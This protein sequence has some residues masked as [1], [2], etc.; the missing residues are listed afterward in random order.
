MRSS[1]NLECAGRLRVGALSLDLAFKSASRAVAVSGP[2]GAGKTTFLRVLA[3][4]AR[5]EDG[6]VSAGTAAWQDSAR[7][8]F[9]PAHQRRAAWVAQDSLLFPHMSVEENLGFARPGRAELEDVAALLEI[10]SL[11]CRRPAH[12]SGGE[13]QR[14]A[15]G[16]A[17]LARPSLLLLDEPFAALDDALRGR[18]MAGLSEFTARREIPFV[19]VTHSREDATA[20]DVER[21]ALE[22]G[23]LMFRG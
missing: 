19:L 10:S 23:R 1:W 13:R 16:R 2:S 15:L 7:G 4:L 14:V 22:G 6:R 11:L 12:L 21:W 5:L 17:M 3:G 20:L 8:L 18:V 9:V